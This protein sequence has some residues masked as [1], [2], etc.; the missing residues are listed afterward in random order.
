M[1]SQLKP[2]AEMKGPILRVRTLLARALPEA[3]TLRISISRVAAKRPLRLQQ[4]GE[5]RTLRS[6]MS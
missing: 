5:I 2:T 6:R 4:P 3:M 1:L